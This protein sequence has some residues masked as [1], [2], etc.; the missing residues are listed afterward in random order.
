MARKRISEE[1]TFAYVIIRSSRWRTNHQTV[2][3]GRS[4]RI[5]MSRHLQLDFLDAKAFYPRTAAATFVSF[6]ASWVLPMLA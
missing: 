1:N 4:D 2:R 6:A 5:V 3:K